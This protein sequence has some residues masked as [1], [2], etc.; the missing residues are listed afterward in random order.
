MCSHPKVAQ[1]E[2]CYKTSEMLGVGDPKSIR[3]KESFIFHHN[4][5]LTPA[6]PRLRKSMQAFSRDG[7]CLWICGTDFSL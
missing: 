5:I 6:K 3:Q 2:I 4:P 1:F 7:L